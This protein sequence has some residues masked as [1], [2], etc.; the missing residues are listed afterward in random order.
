MLSTLK[1]IATLGVML[2][3]SCP[4]SSVEASD[5]QANELLQGYLSS[6]EQGIAMF[7]VKESVVSQQIHSQM[8]SSQLAEEITIQ[9]SANSYLLLVVLVG[10]WFFLMRSNEQ[11]G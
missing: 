8:G 3:M 10:L 6:S 4:V 2:L 1:T 11:H 9:D 7:D 5:L